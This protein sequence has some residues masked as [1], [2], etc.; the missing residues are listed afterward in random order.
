M[1]K[2]L[3]LCIATFFLLCTC[4]SA[5]FADATTGDFKCEKAIVRVA[6]PTKIF[7]IC[8]SSWPTNVTPSV[9]I[10]RFTNRTDPRVAP[11]NM[12]GT[13]TRATI[14][15]GDP[16]ILMVDVDSSQALVGG[17]KYVIALALVSDPSKVGFFDLVTDPKATIASSLAAAD[18]G[19]VF[20]IESPVALASDSGAKFYEKRE[21]AGTEVAHPGADFQIASKD[22]ACSPDDVDCIGRASVT[23]DRRLRQAKATVGVKDLTDVLSQTVSAETPVDISPAS[24]KGK[25]DAS[26][27]YQINHQAS[28]GSR[29]S[30]GINIKANALPGFVSSFWIGR[31]LAQPDIVV[32]I[33]TNDFS[34]KTD[35]TIK[36]GM[37]TTRTH[38]SSFGQ[39]IYGPG[40]AYESNYGFKKNNLLGTFDSRFIP[41][42]WYNTREMRRLKKAVDNNKLSLDDIPTSD[43]KFGTGLE[44]FLGLEAGGA[45]R[46]QDFFNKA[47]TTSIEVPRYSIFRFRPRIHAFLE[48]DRLTLD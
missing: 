8:P 41:D 2:R 13:S 27:Y 7:I 5:S 24:P 46:A 19:R 1:T 34:K 35:D 48:Y 23:L 22:P 25:D 42:G 11:T 40:V 47:K 39:I 9:E 3:K 32:D 20:T 6:G 44:F 36:L 17:A 18:R 31:F 33:G 30:V 15:A 37:T 16:Q 45:L 28:R 43:F 26:Q 10:W 21:K 12:T 38:L 4:P 29:P 14:N